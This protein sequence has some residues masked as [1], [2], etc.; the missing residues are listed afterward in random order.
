[1]KAQERQEA[2]DLLRRVLGAVDRGDLAADGPAAGAVVRRLEG[3]I[4]A[5]EVQDQ[6]PGASP[7]LDGNLQ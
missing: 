6:E 2:A 3:A 1:V 4:L 5:L 7:M